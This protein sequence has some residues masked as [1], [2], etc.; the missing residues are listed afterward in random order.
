MNRHL[1][2]ALGVAVV[3]VAVMTGSTLIKRRP[4]P[5]VGQ[6]PQAE[7][8]PAQAEAAPKVQPAA[9]PAD[10]AAGSPNLESGDPTPDSI[11]G[12]VVIPMPHGPQL[13]LI[14]AHPHKPRAEQV[15][16]LYIPVF[17]VEEAKYEEDKRILRCRI[18]ARL[19][20][21]TLE[22]VTASLRE[23]TGAPAQTAFRVNPVR[24]Q[25]VTIDLQAAHKK[26]ALGSVQA[27]HDIASGPVPVLYRVADEELHDLLA[28]HL[29][30][31][32][33][34]V[35][36]TSPYSAFARNAI[37]VDYAVGAVRDAVEKVLPKGLS[38]DELERHPLVVDRDAAL[39]LQQAVREEFRVRVEGNPAKLAAFEKVV[40]RLLS[41]ITVSEVPLH[42]VT[43]DM[44]DSC[45]V[46]NSEAQ[47]LEVSPNQR[48]TMTRALEEAREKRSAFKHAWDTMREVSTKAS[49]AEAWHNT[50]YEKMKLDARLKVGVAVFSG[51]ASMNL[52]KEFSKSDEGSKAASREAFEKMR[53]AG[54]LTQE[55]S[56][57]YFRKFEGDDRE[58]VAYGKVLHVNRLTALNTLSVKTAIVE[59]GERL[60]RGLYE[61][62]T[63]LPVEDN[64]TQQIDTLWTISKETSSLK[65]QNDAWQRQMEE[66]FQR[67]LL[68]ELAKVSPV[69][70]VVPF[71]GD[72]R[73]LSANWQ[74]ADGSPLKDPNSPLKATLKNGCLPNLTDKVLYGTT[75][76]RQ[77][78]QEGGQAQQNL[79]VQL[80]VDLPVHYRDPSYNWPLKGKEKIWDVEHFIIGSAAL[81]NINGDT[82]GGG[83]T[84]ST[85]EKSYTIATVP[86]FC[87]TYYIVRIK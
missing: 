82:S 1:I 12:A 64:S 21:E 14:P 63:I 15:E 47:R 71:V 27:G 22:R 19:G 17:R 32:C 44:I 24:V 48:T 28:S 61:R 70:S 18:D 23:V 42:E 59:H 43:R 6:Q 62:L 67:R 4:E 74:L 85:G 37:Q 79:K 52:E 3:A 55:T 13:L 51:S 50:L 80:P 72:P 68:D 7:P 29:R 9:S 41:R 16:W 2:A 33:L 25:A 10:N 57:R 20:A 49:D 11:P 69:G 75:N 73:A 38:I 8:P 54:E 56:E 60:S 39:K 34:H 65:R 84:G 35:R 83:V 53:N 76:D 36:T 40:E 81:W 78:L 87:R 30:D 46:W 45:L 5:V 86:P 31:V 26:V 66:Q 58:K 77:L